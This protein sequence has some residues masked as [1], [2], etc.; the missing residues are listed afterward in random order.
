MFE[1][2]AANPMVRWLILC[3]NIHLL[4]RPAGIRKGPVIPSSDGLPLET[5][6]RVTLYRLALQRTSPFATAPT[7]MCHTKGSDY[8]SPAHQ[9]NRSITLR[10]RALRNGVL[11][12]VAT[13][14]V[15]LA[16]SRGLG[17]GSLPNWDRGPDILEPQSEE[18][19]LSLSFALESMHEMNLPGANSMEPLP[20]ILR[21]PDV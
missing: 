20:L 19:G 18:V 21:D 12:R 16:V 2:T 7:R 5:R 17:L 6:N 4:Y 1:P 13:A 14:S 9:F 8:L 15:K 3:V 11:C 10:S